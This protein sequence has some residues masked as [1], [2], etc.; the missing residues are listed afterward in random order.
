MGPGDSDSGRSPSSV[1]SGSGGRG[2]AGEAGG[3]GRGRGQ[4]QKGDV[5]GAER[6]TAP[7]PPAVLGS[8]AA[9]TSGP[10]HPRPGSAHAVLPRAG[11][12]ASGPCHPPESEQSDASRFLWRVDSGPCDGGLGFAVCT[13]VCAGPTRP[14][15]SV[16]PG[17]RLAAARRSSSLNQCSVVLGLF[18]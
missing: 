5:T 11:R 1:R 15:R 13:R 2:V 9:C 4:Q 18:F 3:R 8:P 14:G 12:G 17:P 6:L 7:L 16:A 10:P